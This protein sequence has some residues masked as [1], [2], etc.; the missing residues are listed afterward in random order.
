MTHAQSIAGLKIAA[1]ATMMFGLAFFL[2]LLLPPVHA[3]VYLL[4]DAVVWPIDAAQDLSAA[5]S[6][7]LLAVA[8]GLMAGWG[9]MCWQ[10]TTRVYV[11]QPKLGRRILG[12]SVLTWFVIDSTGSLLVGVPGN[13]LLNIGFALMFLIPLWRYRG[14][15]LELSA[16]KG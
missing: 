14:D 6:R 15:G 8:G 1:A 7:A 5:E 11:A 4:F 10:V 16:V 2:A 3:L 12:T 9:L 13:V